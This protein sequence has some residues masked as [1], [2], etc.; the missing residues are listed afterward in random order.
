M[1]DPKHTPE[2]ARTDARQYARALRTGSDAWAVQIERAWGLYGYSPEVVSTVLS[3]V[4]TGLPLD[5]AI[6]EATS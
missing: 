2:Q 5:A 4:A 6:D 3:A 1:A